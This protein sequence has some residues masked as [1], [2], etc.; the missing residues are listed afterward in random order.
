[1]H[2]T[3]ASLM[4][5]Q[6]LLP[7]I[8]EQKKNGHYVCICGAEDKYVS[9]LRSRGIDVFIHKLKRSLNLYSIL[10]AIF[11]IRQHIKNNRIN[12]VICHTPL[13]SGV[14]RIA[15][16]ISGAHHIIYFAHGLPCSPA[17]NKFIWLFWFSIEK[18][19]GKITDAIILMNDYDEKICKQ[20][21]F[22]KDIKNIFR[23]SGMGVDLKK[24]NNQIENNHYRSIKEELGIKGEK[25]TVICIA[26]IVKEKGVFEYLEA[27]RQI[28]EKRHDVCFLLAGFGPSIKKL[29]M[30]SRR[31][32]LEENLKILG[33]RDDINFLLK[34]SDIFV[35]PSYYF[36]GLPVS[37]LEAMACCKP[38]ITTKHRG[39]EDAVV[40]GVTGYLVPIRNPKKLAEKIIILL[41]DDQKRIYMGRAGRK[42]AER[43]YDIEKCSKLIIDKIETA[44]NR[45]EC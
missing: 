15:A 5:W 28:C 14:G 11:M 17:Q 26:Y 35:L 18:M 36:E 1:M 22:I 42:I 4:A 21:H 41:N 39:C 19:L 45:R 9:I 33:W 10:K 27:A 25:K 44:I 29:K 16:K 37:I 7:L 6:F 13:G 23:I 12:V 3:R 24:F 31:F 20:Y 43:N 8:N 38:V 40:D 32:K 2:I 30:L 34:F